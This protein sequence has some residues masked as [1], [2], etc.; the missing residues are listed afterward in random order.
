MIW[1]DVRDI[2]LE[3]NACNVLECMQCT[4]TRLD[5]Q[6]IAQYI[7]KFNVGRCFCDCGFRFSDICSYI[8]VQVFKLYFKVFGRIIY[9]IEHYP[10]I[11]DYTW[12]IR[13]NILSAHCYMRISNTIT[14]ATQMQA[15]ESCFSS[16]V[17]W[18]PYVTSLVCKRVICVNSR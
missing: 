9:S 1:K 8:I 12:I 7:A 11:F 2:W 3:K 16:N 10:N 14:L 13:V 18:C 17:L 15:R 5:V 6:I 4:S